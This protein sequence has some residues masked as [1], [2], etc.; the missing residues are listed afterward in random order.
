MGGLLGKHDVEQAEVVDRCATRDDE[1]HYRKEGELR[2]EA[3]EHVCEVPGQMAALFLD[4]CLE[5]NSTRSGCWNTSFRD[6]FS[7]S[8]CVCVCVCL[9]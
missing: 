5:R 3:A 4:R 1:R 8:V 2:S 6:S 9:F 7:L